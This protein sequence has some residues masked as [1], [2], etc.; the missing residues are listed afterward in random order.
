MAELVE[1]NT[2]L[3]REEEQKARAELEQIHKLEEAAAT[4]L[5][6]LYRAK[7]S[8]KKVAALR[9]DIAKVVEDLEAKGS[10]L[11]R[12]RSIAKRPSV[13]DRRSPRTPSKICHP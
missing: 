13:S 2:N 8:R 1:S 4:K 7:A 12:L 10:L 6:S 11:R 3:R 9:R 5:Q